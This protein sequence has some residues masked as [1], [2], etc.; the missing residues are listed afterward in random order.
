MKAE[1]SIL[2]LSVQE[3][4][5]E[6]FYKY[7]L[8]TFTNIFRLQLAPRIF[9]KIRCDEPGVLAPN[10]RTDSGNDVGKLVHAANGSR[11]ISYMMQPTNCH[12]TT[13]FNFSQLV[14]MTCNANSISN[15]KRHAQQFLLDKAYLPR[16]GVRRV[17]LY[18][19][20]NVVANYENDRQ[21]DKDGATRFSKLLRPPRQSLLLCVRYTA[22]GSTKASI[23]IVYRGYVN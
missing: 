4:T 1:E 16:C 18:R 11:T 12:I 8:H 20:L 6:R 23:C 13:Q 2:N 15:Y 14:G 21:S 9:I 22:Y 5:Q 7:Y 10:K 17:D 3:N 19:I